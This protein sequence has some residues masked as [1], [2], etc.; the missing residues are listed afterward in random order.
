MPGTSRSPRRPEISSIPEGRELMRL[1]RQRAHRLPARFPYKPPAPSLPATMAAKTEFMRNIRGG[2]ERSTPVWPATSSWTARR[3]STLRWGTA[4]RST[5]GA[6]AISPRRSK[7]QARSL[8]Y[9]GFGCLRDG[10]WERFDNQQWRDNG[11]SPRGIHAQTG[12]GILNGVSGTISINNSGVVTALGSAI[13]PVIEINNGS[14][15]G[16]TFTNTGTVSGEPAG[17]NRLKCRGRR[18]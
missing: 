7:A 16:A 6:S 8:R 12:T 14:T 9:K 10:W 15:Q 3:R 13:G 18:L 17:G 4:S 1:I 11:Y 5:I 2:R